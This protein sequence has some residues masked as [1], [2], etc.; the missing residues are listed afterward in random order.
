V[1]V[2]NCKVCKY[3]IFQVFSLIFG[4]PRI[5]SPPGGRLVKMTNGRI[6]EVTN[7]GR[8]LSSIGPEVNISLWTS[9][10]YLYTP[11]NDMQDAGGLAGNKSWLAHR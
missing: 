5:S 10:V 3:T 7:C 6:T 8:A 2:I 4:V 1:V 9:C 11:I